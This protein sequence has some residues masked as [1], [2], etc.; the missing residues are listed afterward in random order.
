[1]NVKI[2]IIFLLKELRMKMIV[3]QIRLQKDVNLF[4]W[5]NTNKNG[6]IIN[7]KRYYMITILIF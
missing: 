1:M 7:D 4:C 3:F 2:V 5:D 6:K